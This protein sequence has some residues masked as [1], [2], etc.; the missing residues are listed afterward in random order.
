MKRYIYFLLI[1]I[2]LGSLALPSSTALAKDLTE[3]KVVFGGS[4]RLESGQTLDGDLVMFGSVATLEKDSVVNGSVLL[5]GANL[6]ANGDIK[7]DVVGFGGLITLSDSATVEG[8]LL[9]FG[10]HLDQA[11]SA[12][13]LGEVTD[14][15]KAPFT[16]TFPG[17]VKIPEGNINI[18]PN[19]D[20]VWY[21]LKVFLWTA[22]A[23]LVVL[24]AP[25][26]TG[27]VAQASIQQPLVAAG[28]GLL[29]VILAIPLALV[30][31]ITIILSPLGL[32][33][34]LLLG[35]CWA[36]GLISIGLDIGKRFALLVKRDWADP[37][38]AALG[39]FFLMLVLNGTNEM[40][41][42]IGWMFPAV[43]GVIGLG[44][45]LM[46]RF[47]T[48]VYPLLPYPYPYPYPPQPPTPPV[49]PQ[50]VIAPEPVVEKPTSEDGQPDQDIKDNPA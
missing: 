45:V 29:T 13:V 21:V 24:F 3:G 49:I 11:S 15:T 41:P 2:I 47:G 42:C 25:K 20:F 16:F 22:L 37:V 46:T 14:I 12:R 28:L 9:T 33:T 19:M 5:F 17:E 23:T 32:F 44:A 50:P 6:E 7:D 36:F 1:I 35:L 27:R 30:L 18:F 10:A 40:V 39:T 48:Q 43:V 34:L 26:A 8:N 38:S 31:I 4:Y